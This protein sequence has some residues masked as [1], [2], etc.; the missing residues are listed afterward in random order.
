MID[1]RVEPACEPAALMSRRNITSAGALQ[2]RLDAHQRQADQ[3][4]ARHLVLLLLEAGSLAPDFSPPAIGPKATL[5]H[6]VDASDRLTGWLGTNRTSLF[7]SSVPGWRIAELA[8]ALGSLQAGGVAVVCVTSEA[9]ARSALLTRV[10][11]SIET[12]MRT[13]QHSDALTETWLPEI[14][15]YRLKCEVRHT[16]FVS[17]EVDTANNRAEPQRHNR[18]GI[19]PRNQPGNPHREFAV[20]A[21]H[22]LLQHILQ[23]LSDNPAG[24]APLVII[25]GPRGT[26]KSALLGQVH[27]HL[28]A[29]GAA[30]LVS[31]PQRSAIQSLQHF[32]SAAEFTPADR[33][34]RAPPASLIIDEAASLPAAQLQQLV[35]RHTPVILA[36]TTEGYEPSGRAFALRTVEAL[37]ALRPGCL[38]LQTKEPMRW[39]PDDAVD[40]LMRDALLLPV[41]DV[42]SRSP[43]H[44]AV[45]QRSIQIKKLQPQDFLRDPDI[46]RRMVDLLNDNHYQSTLAATD[47]LLTGRVASYV[48]L[49]G[50]Q[51][52]GIATTADEK[53]IPAQLHDDILAN[54]RRLPDRLLPQLLA[55]C[56]NQSSALN[57]DFQRIIRIAVIEGARR[58]GVGRQ[59]VSSLCEG[60]NCLNSV[61]AVFALDDDTA[62]FWQALGFTCFHE[63]QRSNPRSGRTSAAVLRT[64]D[65]VIADTL[66]LAAAI[67]QDNRT[68]ARLVPDPTLDDAL[69]ERLIAGERGVAETRGPLHRLWWSVCDE[70]VPFIEGSPNC[71]GIESSMSPRQRDRAIVDWAQ[72]HVIRP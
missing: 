48:A 52:L 51:W 34:M 33:A 21:Q 36:T 31:A 15:S 54:R 64:R 71:P 45:A 2:S 47:D 1:S 24:N 6:R 66:H 44:V 58:Q 60:R 39:R 25:T 69:L 28:S 70:P 30:P 20:A 17:P 65:P 72:K 68:P 40:P 43:R 27:A 3:T 49:Q 59:L 7:W 50:E 4:G 16:D 42:K 61:G 11:N 8:A 55:R 18:L 63:G 23:Y 57:A 32:S 38:H 67:L 10:L 62:A 9:L 14:C 12:H 19:Q 22:T 13:A 37:S 35:R 5:G 56:S 26:G 29:K 53:A 46:A 41:D